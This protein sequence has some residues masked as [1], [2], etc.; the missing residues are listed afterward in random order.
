MELVTTLQEDPNLQTLNTE[1][2]ELHKQYD[3]VRTMTRS[4]AVAWNL[5]KLQE[6]KYLLA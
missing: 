6:G 2:R 3:E 4:I 1:V 5:D